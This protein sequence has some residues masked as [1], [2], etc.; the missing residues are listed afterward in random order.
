MADDV[1]DCICRRCKSVY[2]KN[3]N[4]EIAFY[5]KIKNVKNA[6]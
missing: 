2:H 3:K 1:L 6:E 5:E 4:V